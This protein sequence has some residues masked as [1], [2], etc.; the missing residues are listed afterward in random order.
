MTPRKTRMSRSS[1]LGSGRTRVAVSSRGRAAAASA[2]DRAPGVDPDPLPRQEEGHGALLRDPETTD[3]IDGKIGAK[4]HAL[5]GV[6][7][8]VGAEERAEKRERVHPR[9]QRVRLAPRSGDVPDQ[10]VLRADGQRHLGAGREA[11]RLA[12]E[13]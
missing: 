11:V 10:D 3:E 9:P 8:E 7:D 1:R 13:L 4:K 12:G 2:M 5:Q 6:A